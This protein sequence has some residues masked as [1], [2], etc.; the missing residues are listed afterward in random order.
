MHVN[1]VSILRIVSPHIL[2]SID[3]SLNLDF[4]PDGR[5]MAPYDNSDACASKSSY[6]I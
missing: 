6:R 5:V 3:G 2:R 1:L 4:F